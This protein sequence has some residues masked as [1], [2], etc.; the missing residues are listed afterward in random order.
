M[1]VLLQMDLEV[2]TGAAHALVH[3]AQYT[4]D[5]ARDVS[6]AMRSRVATWLTPLTNAAHFRDLLDN[7]E[8]NRSS[9][10]EAWI[11]GETLPL[12]LA[13]YSGDEKR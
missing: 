4:G 5:R 10:E 6:P 8:S 12:G 2:T 1:E 9:E 13:L 11:F 7:A 3:I